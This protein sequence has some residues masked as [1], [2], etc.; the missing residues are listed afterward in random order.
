[1]YRFDSDE[2]F[3][4]GISAWGYFVLI[5]YLLADF[6]AELTILLGLFGGVAVGVIVSF[7]RAEELPAE[8]AKPDAPATPQQPAVIR[9]LGTNLFDRFRRPKADEPE[10]PEPEQSQSGRWRSTGKRQT[11]RYLGKRPPRKIG[12]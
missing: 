9:R 1:M 12:K 2:G 7:V 6:N 10:A 5:F 3:R 4:A 11:R 8:D